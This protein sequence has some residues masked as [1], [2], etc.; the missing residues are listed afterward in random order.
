MCRVAVCLLLQGS[1][2]KGWVN[3]IKKSACEVASSLAMEYA[4]RGCEME[5]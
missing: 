2:A 3:Q 5:I 4:H 1:S